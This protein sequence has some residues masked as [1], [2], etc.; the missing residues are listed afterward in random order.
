MAV[1]FFFSR[2]LSGIQGAFA[3]RVTMF[4]IIT[5][6]LYHFYLQVISFFCRLFRYFVCIKTVVMYESR[7]KWVKKEALTNGSSSSPVSMTTFG[8]Y[9]YELIWAQKLF[10]LRLVNLIYIHLS[11]NLCFGFSV[12]PIRKSWIGKCLKKGW[13]TLLKIGNFILPS[14][15]FYSDMDIC[16]TNQSHLKAAKYSQKE[17]NFA[18]FVQ[19]FHF[20]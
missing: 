9:F 19:N 15:Q 14:S 17:I 18:L 4:N 13:A 1:G 10:V 7:I 8:I 2:I 3:A 12:P 5:K 16:R 20:G 11:W 6:N